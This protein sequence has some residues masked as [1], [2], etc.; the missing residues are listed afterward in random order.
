[1]LDSMFRSENGVPRSRSMTVQCV[2]SAGSASLATRLGAGIGGL[3]HLDSLSVDFR[4][5]SI[6]VDGAQAFGEGIGQ[7]PNLRCAARGS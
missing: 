4:G 7:A 6:G 3:Q 5:A 2:G 1:M